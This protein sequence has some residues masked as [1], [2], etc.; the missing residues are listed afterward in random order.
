MA[1]QAWPEEVE[2]VAGSLEQTLRRLRELELSVGRLADVAG[3]PTS[4]L[5]SAVIEAV[6]V[7]FVLLARRERA[8]S[9]PIAESGR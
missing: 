7:P 4:Y 2:R 1:T 8:A 9:D 6:A 3:Y 5:V